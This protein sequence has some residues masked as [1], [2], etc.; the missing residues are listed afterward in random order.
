MYDAVRSGTSQAGYP[1]LLGAA[2]GNG[3]NVGNKVGVIQLVRPI[4]DGRS[5]HCAALTMEGDVYTWGCG[6][7]GRLG[8]GAEADALYRAEVAN[9]KAK[10]EVLEQEEGADLLPPPKKPELNPTETTARRVLCPLMSSDRVLRESQ[11]TESTKRAAVE[12]EKRRTGRGG[13]GGKGGR[14][15]TG[16]RGGIGVGGIGGIGASGRGGGSGGS[17]A[18]G[19]GGDGSTGRAGAGDT[20]V[21]GG[22]MG[23]AG[24][25][26]SASSASVMRGAGVAGAAGAA[27]AAGAAGAASAASAAAGSGRASDR[28]SGS[29]S[30][31]FGSGGGEVGQ[32]G[33]ASSGSGSGAGAGCGAGTG[34]GAGSDTTSDG[35]SGGRGGERGGGAGASGGT[36]GRGGRE[37][38][39]ESKTSD[40]RSSDGTSTDPFGADDASGTSTRDTGGASGAGNTSVADGTGG[41]TSSIQG[42]S[43]SSSA[44]AGG[45][46]MSGS[47]G[48]TSSSLSGGDEFMSSAMLAEPELLGA[49]APPT[50]LGMV[51]QNWE[52]R[53][54]QPSFVLVLRSLN[55]EPSEYTETSLQKVLDFIERQKNE[56]FNL[57]VQN[58]KHETKTAEIERNIEWV[59]KANVSALYEEVADSMPRNSAFEEH[60]VDVPNEVSAHAHVLE[61]IFS[62]LLVNPGYLLRLYVSFVSDS[63]RASRR[64]ANSHHQSSSSSSSAQ[65][66]T[67]F[68]SNS[69]SSSSSSSSTTTTTNSRSPAERIL[70]HDLRFVDLVFDVY[71]DFRSSYNENRFLSLCIHIFKEECQGI[72]ERT[73]GNF[74]L[75]ASR[76]ATRTTVFGRLARRYFALP[77]VVEAATTILEQ[78][79]GT[80]LDNL[81]SSSNNLMSLYYN[82]K[83]QEFDGVLM[84]PEQVEPVEEPMKLYTFDY[85]PNR[86]ACYVDS[87]KTDDDCDPNMSTKN[88]NSTFCFFYLLCCYDCV[89]LCCKR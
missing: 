8:H 87:K 59:V 72:A 27:S 2:V 11:M 22:G 61:M 69:S 38:E 75:F 84:S 68:S 79:L 32:D 35:S 28:S 3:R 64:L 10:N 31:G 83:R 26:G 6:V 36:G 25:A 33:Q 50:K 77:H 21:A 80:V 81:S 51:V 78:Q 29:G 14:S 66:S 58:G 73:G 7:Y 13:T 89:I 57:L 86:T 76:F 47:G 20:A 85:N 60:G 18:R 52:I 49:G 56:V 1:L 63:S 45:S 42:S 54:L 17:G 19:G 43:S 5:N 40:G 37:D 44:A 67:S 74:A 88:M 15:G 4:A 55:A 39:S 53:R 30:D 12:E 23:G 34:S 16:E 9:V 70:Q 71:G 24:G 48:D 41:D 62:L 46:A 65:A 82:R